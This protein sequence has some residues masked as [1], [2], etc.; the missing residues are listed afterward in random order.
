MAMAVY[1]LT[2]TKANLMKAQQMLALM[3]SS[4]DLLDKKRV[5]LMRELKKVDQQ[6]KETERRLQ[7]KLTVFQSTIDRAFILM[8]RDRLEHLAD[9]IALD[10]RVE[11]IPKSY[12]GIV[13]DSYYFR[14]EEAPMEDIH[15]ARMEETLREFK[16][17]LLD[18][19]SLVNTAKRLERE[20]LKT[21]KRAN[22]LDKVQIP[23]Y[24][25]IAAEI[26]ASLEE[27]ER[28]EFFRLKLLK[29]KKVES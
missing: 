5:A 14:K 19:A 1:K 4:Y 29:K 3:E 27:K 21:Q 8:G 13:M 24:R 20:M 23:K 2:P 22:A 18:M 10:R 6:R 15:L 26:Q 11:R 7:E 12:M 25:S 9:S 17:I 16:E 28:E